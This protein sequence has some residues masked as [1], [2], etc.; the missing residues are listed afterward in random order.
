[1]EKNKPIK[2]EKGA[3]FYMV[4]L[5]NDLKITKHKIT[6]IHLREMEG[7]YVNEDVFY[8]TNKSGYSFYFY[9]SHFNMCINPPIDTEHFASYIH[10]RSR[11]AISKHLIF[12]DINEANKFIV[13]HLINHEI[14][15]IKF[16]SDNLREEY[17]KLIARIDVLEKKKQEILNSPQQK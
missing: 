15:I 12:S 5:D 8:I 13:K 16:Q 4:N 9:S 17:L 3:I 2:I 7:N 6:S 10:K 1:M 14:D 11:T